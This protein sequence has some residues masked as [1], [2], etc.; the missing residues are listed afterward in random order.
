VEYTIEGDGE[1]RTIQAKGALKFG[2]HPIV[3]SISELIQLK[4]VNE[5]VL[6]LTDLEGIDSSVSGSSSRS[7]RPPARTGSRSRFP[8]SGVGYARPSTFSSSTGNSPLSE[9]RFTPAR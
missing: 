5:I 8:V 1:S 7:I 2:D 3:P 6:D 4:A 9:A